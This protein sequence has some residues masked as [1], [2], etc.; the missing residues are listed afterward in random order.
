[1]IESDGAVAKGAFKINRE[2]MVLGL[3]CAEKLTLA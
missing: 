1:M 3:R 2:E